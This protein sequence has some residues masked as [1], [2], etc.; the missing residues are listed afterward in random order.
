VVFAVTE[1]V[2]VVWI[3]DS[4]LLNVIMLIHPIEAIKTWQLVH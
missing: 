4:L 2:L 1:V 3:K